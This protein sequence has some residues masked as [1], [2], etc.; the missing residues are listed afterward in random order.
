[1]EKLIT[2]SIDSKNNSITIFCHLYISK[3]YLL[4]GKPDLA[5]NILLKA[6][7]LAR[8][9][10]YSFSLMKTYKLLSKCYLHQSV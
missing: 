3:M 8:V 5:I 2:A 1:M 9:Y 6:K 10:N 7:L 4:L